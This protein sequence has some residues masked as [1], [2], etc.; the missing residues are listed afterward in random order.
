MGA[1]AAVR[2]L[3]IARSKTLN[4]LICRKRSVTMA[5]SLD[6]LEEAFQQALRYRSDLAN[7]G[8]AP[9]RTYHE[10]RDAFAEALPE[11]GSDGRAVIRQLAKTGEPGL[12]QMGHPRFVGWVL[13]ASHP[14]GIAADWLASAW[15]QNSGYHTPTPTTAAVE[16]VAANW[17]LELLDLPREAS[18]GFVTGATVGNFVALA[19]A[20]GKTLRAHG[21]ETQ[22][23]CSAP[24]KS[25]S[26]SAMTRTPPSTL[27][28]SI[29]GWATTGSSVS[30]RTAK[31]A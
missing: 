24:P 18:I 1:L 4:P 7:L 13:G 2:A 6:A 9:Q 16:E 10:M 19:A 23:A 22:M 11:G 21:W 29:L 31:G 26:S 3:G 12:M 25:T 17:L 28:C 14:T 27:R 8:C 30:I 5:V 20:R 15:G